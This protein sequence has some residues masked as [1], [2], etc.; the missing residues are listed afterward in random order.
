MR[1]TQGSGGGGRGAGQ[2][3]VSRQ[4]GVHSKEGHGARG[5][6]SLEG[7]WEPWP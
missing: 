1:G 2:R 4:Q 5:V 3:E 6:Q 7:Q